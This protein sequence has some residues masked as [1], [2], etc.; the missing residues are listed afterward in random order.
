ML[1]LI[2]LEQFI[3]FSEYG[4]LSKAAEKLNISQPTITRTMQRVEDSFGIPLFIRSKNKIELSES[5]MKAVEYSRNLL[6]DADNTIHLV[7]QFYKGLHTVSVESCAPAPLWSF[8]PELSSRVPEKSIISRIAPIS[9]II[10]NIRSD[11]SDIGILPHPVDLDGIHCVSLMKE[12]LSVCVRPEHDLAHKNSL[13]FHELNG[14][15][16]LLRSQIGFWNEL[17]HEK[18]PSSKF[19]IQT[20]E[21]A[22]NELIRESSLPFFA[23]N[24]TKDTQGL[25]KDR[26]RIPITDPE[27]NVTYYMI[28]KYSWSL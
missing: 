13:S 7:Q 26:V 6:A 25:I 2:E 19:L 14:F 28:S 21:F 17:C 27:A 12:S 20:D 3:A 16:F 9:E 15:N 4:T 18:M 11:H 10:E 23:T 8:L 22:F 5:G 1:N 24:L